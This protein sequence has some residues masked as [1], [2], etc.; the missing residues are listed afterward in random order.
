VVTCKNKIEIARNILNNAASMN[1]SKELLLKISQKL[2]E[3]IVGYYR[4]EKNK[5]DAGKGEKSQG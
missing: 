1:I 5:N 4:N 2:D 3:Y